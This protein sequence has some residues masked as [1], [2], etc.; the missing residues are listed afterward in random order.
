MA[1]RPARGSQSRKKHRIMKENSRRSGTWRE[2]EQEK[3][4]KDHVMLDTVKEIEKTKRKAKSLQRIQVNST[5]T[6]LTTNPARWD[7]YL[8]R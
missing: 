5:T 7:K 4:D 3:R 8:N 2:R 6:I 1:T